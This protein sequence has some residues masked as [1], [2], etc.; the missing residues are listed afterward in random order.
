MG[1]GII[2]ESEVGQGT[3]FRFT[4]LSK[5]N[6]P[7]ADPGY[8]GGVLKGK[9]ICIVDDNATNRCILEQYASQWEMSS[10]SAS[11]GPQA[12][13]LLR[14]AYA[15]EHPLMQRFFDL[16]MPDM[17]GFE[18]GRAISTDPVLGATRFF[19]DISW[20]TRTG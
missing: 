11:G 4:I 12:L 1:G 13:E 14:T 16:Q 20:D 5:Q 2:L 15:L 17:D 9:R 8:P 18:L 6:Q 3:A 7:C 19:A 10:V